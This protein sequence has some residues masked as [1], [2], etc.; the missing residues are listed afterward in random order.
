M[1]KVIEVPKKHKWI[2]ADP[3]N[4]ESLKT[5]KAVDITEDCPERFRTILVFTKTKC[6]RL[7]QISL[8]FGDKVF[9][10]MHI[11]FFVDELET[12]MDLTPPND[13]FGMW[14]YMMGLSKLELRGIIEE[15]APD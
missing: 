13:T 7:V 12:Q 11:H 14:A 8:P 1:A 9:G 3:D 15:N 2:I 4:G 6:G 10:G 5:I